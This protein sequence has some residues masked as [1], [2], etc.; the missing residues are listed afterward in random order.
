MILL[1]LFATGMTSSSPQTQEI[2][3]GITAAL[4]IDATVVRFLLVLFPFLIAQNLLGR[5]YLDDGKPS[6]ASIAFYDNYTPWTN[7]VR[8]PRSAAHLQDEVA[9]QL[10]GERLQ[11]DLFFEALRRTL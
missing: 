2:C 4:A 3:T 6:L 10:E 8:N 9:K 1:G 11:A 5:A 7:G